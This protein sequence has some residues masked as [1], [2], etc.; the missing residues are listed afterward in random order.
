M[1][2]EFI[3]TLVIPN[4]TKI[5][6]L[7]MDGL[8]GLPMDGRDQTELEAARTPNLDQLARKSV[9]GL[10]DPI[11]YGVTPGSGPAHF[12][13]FGY[14]PIKNNIGRGIL[15]AAG[16]DFP[17]TERDLLIRLNFATID[18]NGV[19]VDRRA[20][21]IDNETNKRICRKLQDSIKKLSDVEVIFEPVREHRALLALRGGDLREEIQETDPQ[22]TGLP[23]LPPD[24]LVPEAEGTATLLKELV[25]KAREVLS[26]EAKANMLLLRGYS[27]Y[28]R[29]PSLKERFGLNALAIANYPM[30]RGI[31][32]LLGM[33]IGPLPQTIEEEF[34]A[35]SEHYREYDFFFVHVKPTDSRGEDGNFEAK[36]KVIEEVDALVPLVTD[37]NP[38]V[39]VVTG[40]HSTPAA[41][42]SHSWHPLPVILYST[43]CRPDRVERFSERDCVYGGIGRMPMVHLMGLALAHARRLEKF[44]A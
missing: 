20:G 10:L 9:C 37:L 15:E 33:V 29:Y 38:D 28:R 26:D 44:G 8:G 4:D 13:L 23:F 42:A 35:L 31:A 11:G 12:A 40:D 5:V 16:I 41:L 1:D 27:R 7:I 22:K 3:D 34:K 18:K 24:A 21:R 30:Y 6:F 17:M 39:L 14:D 19:V 25:D 32:R 43:T 2:P 36:V